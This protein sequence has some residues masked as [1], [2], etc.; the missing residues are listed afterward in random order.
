M[1]RQTSA[2]CLVL[3]SA[4]ALCG[5]TRES[6]N[7]IKRPSLERETFERQILDLSRL[8]DLATAEERLTPT[9]EPH[10]AEDTPMDDSIENELVLDEL[11]NVL[12]QLESTLATEAMWDVEVP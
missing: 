2:R 12:E 11:D 7:R 1:Q 3:V 10:P 5:C 9:A 6:N 4:V 8:E